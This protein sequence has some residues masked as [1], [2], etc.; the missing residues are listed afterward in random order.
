MCRKSRP[1]RAPGQR[2]P[3]GWLAEADRTRCG[4]VLVKG[5]PARAMLAEAWRAGLVFDKSGHR[6]QRLLC[7]AHAVRL[8]VLVHG[9][10]H[11]RQVEV[12]DDDVSARRE[13][14]NV[15]RMYVEGKADRGRADKPEHVCQLAEA[16]RGWPRLEAALSL[17]WLDLAPA[18]V[19]KLEGDLAKEGS[20]Y[21]RLFPTERGAGRARRARQAPTRRRRRRCG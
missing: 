13:T 1:D 16:G 8:A 20:G 10:A 17:I 5:K 2:G 18:G 12:V 7:L 11:G 9:C 19:S 21:G 14:P 3:S 4:P 15:C 6:Q